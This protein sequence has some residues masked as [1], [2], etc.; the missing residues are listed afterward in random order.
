MRAGG[1]GC[2]EEKRRDE[3]DLERVVVLPYTVLPP[4]PL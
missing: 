4:Q 1:S 2:G 3:E